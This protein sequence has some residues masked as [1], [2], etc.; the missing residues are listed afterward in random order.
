MVIVVNKAYAKQ[1][2]ISTSPVVFPWVKYRTSTVFEQCII[3][4]AVRQSW[5]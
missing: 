4:L 1:R 3:Y 2:T 5:A